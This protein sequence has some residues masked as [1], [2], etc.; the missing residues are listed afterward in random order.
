MQ[1][2][3]RKRP[4]KRADDTFAACVPLVQ[5]L[6]QATIKHER[7]LRFRGKTNGESPSRTDPRR[8]AV[9]QAPACLNQNRAVRLPSFFCQWV[10]FPEE[11]FN[12]DFA[13]W[14]FIRQINYEDVSSTALRCCPEYS[15]PGISS[16]IFFFVT[17]H[18]A[19]GQLW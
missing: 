12:S 18:A 9:C 3:G 10:N 14:L 16:H 5:L 7:D 2:R 6:T 19:N 13:E 17:L 4:D 1:S 15:L 11:C 8:Y